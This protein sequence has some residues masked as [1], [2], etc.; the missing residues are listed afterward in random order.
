MKE[1]AYQAYLIKKLKQLFPDCV[2]LKN[3]SG[4]IQGI[5]DLTILFKDRWAMLEIK[6][7]EKARLQPNQKHYVEALD[8][9][10]FAAFIHPENENEV[11]NEL[12]RTF[13][14]FG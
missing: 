12:Q 1:N 10:S 13:G 8:K 9:M 7:S 6:I 3:D 4:Y 2:I 5:P 14:T 11:L